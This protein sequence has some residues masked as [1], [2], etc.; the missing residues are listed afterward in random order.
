MAAAPELSNE[1]VRRARLLSM[2]VAK[3]QPRTVAEAAGALCGIQAQDYN[4]AALGIR[5]RSKGLT[6]AD[7]DM[8]MFQDRTVARTWLMRETI[9]LVPAADLH[10][11]LSLF[12][13]RNAAASRKRAPGLGLNE[14]DGEKGMKAIRRAAE[15]TGAATRAEITTA[16]KKA[17]IGVD[18][19]NRVP[20]HLV[21]RAGS[22]GIIVEVAPKGGKQAF[23]SLPDWIPAA[24]ELDRPAALERLARGYLAAFQPAS[25]TDFAAWS[26][27]PAGELNAGIEKLAGELAEVFV[28]GSKAWVFEKD[29]PRLK[30]VRPVGLRLLPAF[31]GL[32]LGYKSREFAID[33]QH[34]KA[35]W[36]GGGV[37]RPVVTVDGRATGT[38]KVTRNAKGPY[39]VVQP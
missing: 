10:W 36:P 6:A 20:M 8:A 38:W 23:G 18:P 4:A 39:V 34:L 22:L 33:P 13:A 2:G 29:L 5:V 1:L 9:H 3:A 27:L 15:K 28:G 31:D 26:G 30:K 16:L 12:G 37:I 24:E 14:A 19:L 35:I 21:R 17:G 25:R 32:I 7:V 11:M